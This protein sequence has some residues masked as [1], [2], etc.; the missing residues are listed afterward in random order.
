MGGD[1]LYYYLSYCKLLQ[2]LPRWLSGKE[3]ACN[4]GAEDSIPSQEDPLQ[5]VTT[6]HPS[7]LARITQGPKESGA[8]VHGVAKNRTRLSDWAQTSPKSKHKREQELHKNVK[9]IRIP[10]K[11]L[12]ALIKSFLILGTFW[13][14]RVHL[15]MQGM[16]VWSLIGELRSHMLQSKN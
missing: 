15:P 2:G 16:Q 7:I 5:E 1:L 11:M 14:L 13:W 10:S 9:Q 12:T 3:S 6:T 4:A 8:T